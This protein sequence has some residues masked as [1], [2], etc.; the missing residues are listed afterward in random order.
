M[1]IL[2]VQAQ[3]PSKT[4]SGVYFSN[5]IKGLAGEMDQACVYGAYPGYDWDLLPEDRQYVL[6]FPNSYCDF[7]LPGM[8]DVM[9]YE[10]TVYG[11]MTPAMI[12]QWKYAFLEVLT[13]AYAEFQPDVIL[14]HHLW[15]LTD[16]VRQWFPEAKIFAICHNT[17]LRQAQHHP[18]LAAQYTRHIKDLDQ[19]FALSSQQIDRIVATYGLAPEQIAVLGGGYDDKIFYFEDQQ[20]TEPLQLLYAGKIAEAKGVFALI[21]AFT[22]QL[23]DRQDLQLH[24]VGNG[25]PE[26]LAKM[27]ELIAGDARIHY[28]AAVPQDHLA[29]LFRQAAVFILPSYYEGL[30]LVVVEAMA[31]GC[32]TVVAD[33]PALVDQLDDRLNQSEL[34]EYIHLP[35]LVNQDEPVA[36]DLPAYCEALAQAIV[37][38]A[39]RFRQKPQLAASYKE[40]IRKN[41]WPGLVDYL[42]DFL[43]QA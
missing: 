2:H 22:Q 42:L 35:G 26:S 36:E 37:R 7:P 20:V 23:K 41:S 10:S 3:L 39:N 31:C 15:F 25:N 38:Q 4:G 9:P 5:L 18:Q 6:T 30:P 16:M 29:Q 21:E 32:Y 8:S 13:K 24:L 14:C 11:E 43:K 17:D 33:F 19:V 34:I 1:R 40:E 28:Q 27:H 12:R